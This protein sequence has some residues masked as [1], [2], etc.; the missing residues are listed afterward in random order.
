MPL[1]VETAGPTLTPRPTEGE[2][3]RSMIGR[4]KVGF[5]RLVQ[6]TVRRYNTPQCARL[7]HS[8]LV[9]CVHGRHASTAT[10]LQ[11][12]SRTEGHLTCAC[13]Q[14]L[15]LFLTVLRYSRQRLAGIASHV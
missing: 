12:M 8:T 13:Q 3:R 11:Q 5:R 2:T 7:C 4:C 14:V 10:L 15:L 9:E 6:A 1:P